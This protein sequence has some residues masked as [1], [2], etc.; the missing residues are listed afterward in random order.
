MSVT[1]NLNLR[2]KTS[3]QK[4]AKSQID[5]VNSSIKRAVKSIAAFAAGFIAVQKATAFMGDSIKIAEQYSTAISRLE[6]NFAN[7]GKS[8]KSLTL[9]LRRYSRAQSIA[10][11]TSRIMI[12]A[13]SA[14]LSIFTQNEKVIRDSLPVL[15]DW[16]A[17]M[18]TDL[19]S[20]TKQFTESLS[21]PARGLRTL[22]R[23]GLQVSDSLREQIDSFVEAGDQAGAYNTIIDQ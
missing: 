5:S 8:S 17:A 15:E 20:A 11:G 18:G 2:M 16:A 21:D 9:E 19:V 10:T 7:V 12:A 13:A 1:K 4:V 14:Q 3:G 23:R 22:E 6:Q